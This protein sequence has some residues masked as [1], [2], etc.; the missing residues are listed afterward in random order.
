MRADLVGISFAWQAH[1]AFYLPVRAPM[2]FKHLDI[3]AVREKLAPI[4]ADASIKKIGQ[5]IKYDMLVLQNSKMP[6]KGIYFDTMV[7]S[8]CLDPLRDSHSMNAM[9]LDFLNY[10][11]ITIDHPYW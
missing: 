11:C 6:L 2:G 5:N 10:E 9:A 3:A 7:A 1:K 8:Y 4:F